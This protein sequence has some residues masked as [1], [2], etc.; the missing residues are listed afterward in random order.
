MSFRG[1]DASL[2]LAPLYLDANASAPPVP[3]ALEALRAAALVGANPSSP[4]ALGRAARRILDDARRHVAMALGGRDKE[5]TFTSGASEANRW[6]VDAVVTAAEREGRVPLVVT[7]PFE[8]PSLAKPLLAAAEKQR[9][10]LRTLAVTKEGALVLEDDD[11]LHAA[12]AVFVTAAHNETGVLPCLD[13]VLARVKPGALVAVDAAQATA[14]L[15]TLPSRVDAVVVSAH[16]M[17]GLPGV[18]GLLLRGQARTLPTPWSGGGQEGGRRP[19]TEALPLVAAFGAA[20][21]VVERTREESRLTAPLRD[22]LE[23]ALLE[24]WPGAAV[25]GREVPRLPNTSAITVPHVDGEALRMAIDL[26]GVC[27]GFG[28]ACSALAPE[29]SPSLLALGLTRDQAR[30]TV[31]L[32]LSPGSDDGLVDEAV[33]RL[34][35]ALPR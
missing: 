10:V 22:R 17:G 30:A 19:G 12:D 15:P 24:A 27:V 21:A 1:P 16:K 23:H 3:E 18:G 28:S 7:S 14:R 9:L 5:L 32:S 25:V 33:L 8:H 26:A 34:T 6:L 20:A 11:S 29:P 35:R 31:R 4:H 13:D 2:S